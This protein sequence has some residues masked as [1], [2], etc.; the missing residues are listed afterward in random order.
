MKA[1]TTIIIAV[2]LSLQACILF[3]G[4]ELSSV[5]VTNHNST[6]TIVSLAPSTPIEAN[7]E[8][9]T[10]NDLY[11]LMLVT[12]TEATF[13]DM[14]SESTSI[15]NLAPVTPVTAD[16]DDAIEI[17][18]INITILVPVTPTEADFE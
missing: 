4:N 5:P 13:E 9:I 1:T 15:I 3:A 18:T 8:D 7:F 12:P 14:P 17:D 10:M 2:V 16:F 6:I 11:N